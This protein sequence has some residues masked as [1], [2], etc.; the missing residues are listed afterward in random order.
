MATLIF[1]IETNGLMPDVSKVHSL[2]IYEVETERTW[3]CHDQ[4]GASSPTIAEGLALLSAADTLIGHNI[5]GYDIPVLK[6]L[7]NDFKL[8]DGVIV[9]DTLILARLCWPDTKV[10][11]AKLAANGKLPRKLVGRHSLEAWGYRLG[12]LKDEYAGDPRIADKDERWEKRWDQWNP[13]MQKYCEQDVA[14]TRA[15]YHRLLREITGPDGKEIDAVQLEH[16]VDRIIRRQ[17]E[18]GVAVSTERIEALVQ[19]L[20]RRQ[21]ELAQQLQEMIP[22]WEV[23][24]PFT[25]KANNKKRGYVKGVPTEKVTTITFNPGSRHHVADR[26]I[27]LHGWKPS[28]F[29]GDGH[30]VVDDD[31]LSALP[32]PEAVLLSE[33][34]MV[35]K[36]LGAAAEG[37]NAWLKMAKN[38]RIHGQVTPNGAHTGRM[39]HRAPNLGQ[40]PANDA[41]YGE[42]CRA[43]FVAGEGYVLVG[44][45]ADALELRD[46]GGY[47]H[48]YDGGS[49]IETILRGDKNAGTDMHSVNA[50]AIGLDPKKLYPV[51]TRMMSGR[52]IAKVFFYAFIYGAGDEKLGWI[53]GVFGKKVARPNRRT[54]EVR[55]VDTK[56]MAAGKAAKDNLMRNLP[57]LKQVIDRVKKIVGDLGFVR[58][59]DGRKLRAR[60]QHAALNTL[61]Q[62]A[63]AIQMKRA[64]V[65]LDTDLQGEGLVPGDDYEF[66][67]NVHDEW[68]IEARPHIADRVGTLA[69]DAIRK[70]GEYYAFKCPLAGNYQVGADWSQ[71]H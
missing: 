12:V 63:G 54:G 19:T 43:C 17:V 48:R 27:T 66:V 26:L 68:Q 15:L 34:Y 38:G 39:T 9:R 55:M 21:A 5:T 40:V 33:Y 7:F 6:H 1:D 3:S 36:R 28:E 18:R 53:L 30:P 24:T 41:P 25:P 50:R 47:M 29:T 58:G 59:L 11:D 62:A 71:T 37:K 46:L 57:A 52:D 20:L 64:L 60:S 44:C 42:E 10:N 51:G 69:A 16:D 23:R 13:T 49:Y 70:A 22:P 45:D 8:R 32:Y 61:L 35:Q 65:I 2:I 4:P 67:L 14:A 31:V 56:A